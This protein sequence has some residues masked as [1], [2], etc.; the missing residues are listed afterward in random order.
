[1]KKLKRRLDLEETLLEFLFKWQRPIRIGDMR[2]ELE[3]LGT[4][5]AHSSLNSMIERL[6]A[7]GLVVW[8]K[9]GT[10]EI[11]KAGENK[12]AH[13]MRHLHL[14]TMFL[15]KTLDISHDAARE[16]SINLSRAIS[17]R[18]IEKISHFLNNPKRCWCNEQI[19]FIDECQ[20]KST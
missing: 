9:Y 2:K 3:K 14:L 12:I 18:L 16:E 4:K 8:E 6:E 15:M 19:P 17:C 11:T 20:V 1:M 7:E 10:V 13:K 5:I